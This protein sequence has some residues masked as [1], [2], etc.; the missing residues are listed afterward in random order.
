V[1]LDEGIMKQY[2]TRG[3]TEAAMQRKEKS[4]H[5]HATLHYLLLYCFSSELETGFGSSKS[6]RSECPMSAREHLFG[7]LRAPED[8]VEHHRHVSYKDNQHLW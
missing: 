2:I 7:D 4:K 8:M 5:T 6:E 1:G 3:G